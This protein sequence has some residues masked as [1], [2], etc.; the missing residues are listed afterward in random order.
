[1]LGSC[2]HEPKHRITE[3]SP[4]IIRKKY[5]L[6]SLFCEECYNKPFAGKNLLQVFLILKLGEIADAITTVSK[7]IAQLTMLA[8]IFTGVATG[9]GYLSILCYLKFGWMKW[10]IV[11][12]KDTFS[13]K[14]YFAFERGAA[15]LGLIIMTACAYYMISSGI[16]TVIYWLKDNYDLSK[17]ITKSNKSVHISTEN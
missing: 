16:K 12:N 1:M 7:T 6:D 11:G 5:E 4:R 8:F 17:R 9:L 13:Y 14:F 2:N 3:N 15:L 10:L